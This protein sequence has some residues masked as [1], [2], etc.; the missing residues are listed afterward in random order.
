MILLLARVLLHVAVSAVAVPAVAQTPPARPDPTDAKAAVP[1]LS[2]P[3]TLSADRHRDVQ[4]LPWRQAND[5]VRDIGGWR[6]YARAAQAAASAASSSTA[7]H[8]ARHTP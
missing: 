2:I 8:G 3:L 4:P 5:T 6:A 1:A 7:G